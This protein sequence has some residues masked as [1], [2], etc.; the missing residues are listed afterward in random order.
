APPD[1]GRPHARPAR[2]GTPVAVGGA[3]LLQETAMPA[4]PPRPTRRALLSIGLA[5]AALALGATAPAAAE[6]RV[7]KMGSL[8][9]IHSIAPYFYE[10]FTPPGYKVEIIP[11]D[12][13]TDGK[14]AV[15]TSSVDFRMF[16]LAA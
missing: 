4:L 16:G 5:A 14:N 13:P 11:F 10:R 8:K 12:S 1:R 15:V 9:L 7:I 6:D 2:D 3:S